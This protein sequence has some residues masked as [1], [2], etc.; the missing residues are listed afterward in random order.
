MVRNHPVSSRGSSDHRIHPRKSLPVGY[1][2]VR[3]RLPGKQRFSLTGH[4]YDVSMS[5]IRFE[6][7][8]PL[9]IGKAVDL[10]F[11]LP[12]AGAE[13]SAHTI[14]AKARCVRLH[15][16]ELDLLDH[17]PVRMGACFIDMPKPTDQRQLAAYLDA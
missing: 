5:G 16:D 9:P 8:S 4:A 7:D 11:N 14:R 1:A 3:V 15:D 2:Q 17:G 6:L 12:A 10:Q 13:T